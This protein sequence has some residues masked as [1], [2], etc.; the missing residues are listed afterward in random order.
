MV[1]CI[2]KI[3]RLKLRT[4]DY[5]KDD[6]TVLNTCVSQPGNVSTDAVKSSRRYVAYGISIF[7]SSS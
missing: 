4:V 3:T 7:T 1:Q 2:I 6:G 5:S